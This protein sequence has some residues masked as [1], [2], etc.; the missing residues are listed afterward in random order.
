MIAHAR[1][2]GYAGR[3]VASVN[4]LVPKPGT[5]YQWLAMVP[6]DVIDRRAKRLR[7]LVSGI[8]N[9]YF[10]IKSERHSSTR[11]CSRRDGRWPCSPRLPSA[12]AASG[13]RGRD[14]RDGLLH[15]PGPERQSC[16]P[17]TIDGG[18][19]ASS[20]RSRQACAANGRFH[21]NG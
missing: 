7:S 12:T 20:A 17:G 8:D 4:P 13:G 14:R 16:R 5:A 15:L 10:N 21:R 3:I 6:T 9:V 11:R 18:L 19:K 1:S 2:K